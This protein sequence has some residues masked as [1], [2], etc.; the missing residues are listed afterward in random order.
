MSGK[1]K[2]GVIY[3]SEF[4]LNTFFDLSVKFSERINLKHEINQK[5][6]KNI[7]WQKNC[8]KVLIL[9]DFLSLFVFLYMDYI[10]N[11]NLIYS[12]FISN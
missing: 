10:S 2:F 3:L 1:D 5:L 4:S 8:S 6:T 11:I 7:E 9:S 12:I